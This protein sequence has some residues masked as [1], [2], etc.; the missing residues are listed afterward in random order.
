MK[1]RNW[2]LRLTDRRKSDLIGSCAILTSHT[3]SSK[4]T[5]NFSLIAEDARRQFNLYITVPRNGIFVID[6][7]S[8]GRWVVIYDGTI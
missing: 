7:H 2:L 4:R 5:G 3:E 8:E 6:G 1:E